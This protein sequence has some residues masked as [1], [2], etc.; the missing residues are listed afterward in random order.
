M[1]TR[2][3]S[4]LNVEM[5]FSMLDGFIT[6]NECFYVRNHFP[7]PSV[8]SKTWRLKVDGAVET[9]FEIGY[10][11]LLEMEMR[12]FTATL[13]CAGNG[14]AFLQPPP[15]ATL[16]ELGA[17]GN[18]EW[19]GV[20][21]SALLERAGM[22]ADAVDVILEGADNGEAEKP[23][24][25]GG[26]LY[27]SR[28]VPRRKACRD[29]LLAVRMNGTPLSPAHGFTVRAIVPGWYAAASVKWLTR[30]VVSDQVFAGYYQTVDYS[31]WEKRDG[32]PTLVPIQ[33]LQVKA[34]IARP[35]MREVVPANSDYRMHGAA[36]TS[37]VEI[38]K[39]E[40]SENS[41]ATWRD[42]KLL[43]QP[44]PNAWQLWEFAWRT[45]SVPGKV[46]LMARA[47]DARG[48]TQLQQHPADRGHY[49]ISHCLAIAVDVR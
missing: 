20:P 12:T 15:A 47:T 32:L 29:V 7:V 1:I 30:I 23:P 49:L 11:A 9:P 44:V 28:S 10:E 41:G 6:P 14:R 43:G 39:V 37:D 40:I 17:V 19:T 3:K 18:A 35:A 46:A 31:Y 5:P 21:L 33:E 4:P 42:A 48:R 24:R 8:D 45:P 2:E 25:P 36:W 26:L 38:V 16:W 13:E 27:F 34:E 22:N